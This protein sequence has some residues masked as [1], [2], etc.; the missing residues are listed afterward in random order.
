MFCKCSV[1]F[2]IMRSSHFLL[3]CQR[4]LPG[5]RISLVVVCLQHTK[6]ADITA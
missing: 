2:L 3:M 5:K 1:V 6:A 4:L